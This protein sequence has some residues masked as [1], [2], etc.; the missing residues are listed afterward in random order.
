MRRRHFLIMSFV[1]VP[2][3]YA[4][5]EAGDEAP[6]TYTNPIIETIGPADPH[7][8]K[9]EGV[10]YLYPTHDGRGYDV[11]TSTDLVDWKKSGRCF[12]DDRGGLWAP[13]VFHHAS[14]DGKFYLY[15]TAGPRGSKQIGVAVATSPL[16]PFE[17]AGT[18]FEKAI[19]AHMFEDDDGA[20]Y[21]YYVD[22]S[23]PNNIR[24]QPMEDPLRK[25]GESKPVIAPTEPWEQAH[26]RV[27]EGPWMMKRN[28]VYY[29]MYSGSGANGPDYAIGYATSA[30]PLGPFDKYPGN[31]IAKRGGCVFG[32]GHHCVVEGPDGG[33]W[34]VYH[35]KADADVNWKRFLAIDPLWFDD[36]G[37]I[38]TKTTRGTP[39]PAP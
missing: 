19:D 8:I 20:L 38:H 27:T 16:G 39:Q 15:Y 9:H 37:R 31:P 35:Q 7:V 26:G 21:L 17:N 29:L 3:V 33:Y 36:Q 34:M 28:G 14:G 6:R 23:R 32:P 11:Y 5:A 18:L 4:T 10:Y 24:V 2:V 13:D 25:K 1:F 12:E 22:L 30:S